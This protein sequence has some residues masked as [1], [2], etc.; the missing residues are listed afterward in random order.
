[1]SRPGS[2]SS[3]RLLSCRLAPVAIAAAML[4][5]AAAADA[6]S[7]ALGVLDQVTLD[8]QLASRTWIARVLEATTN[9]FFWLALLEFVSAGRMFMLATP[10]AREQ[11]GGQFLV[12]IM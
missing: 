6:Q 9:L 2:R 7:Q 3:L 4:L 11:K 8:Y 12:K 10:H 1:M 5:T